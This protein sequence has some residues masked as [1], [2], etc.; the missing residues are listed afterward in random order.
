M[1]LYCFYMFINANEV[2]VKAWLRSHFSGDPEISCVYQPLA[3][4]CNCG[5]HLWPHRIAIRKC[6]KG[7][8]NAKLK[9][10]YQI[11]VIAVTLC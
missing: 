7:K 4:R 3:L 9:N 11:N 2:V 5:R 8:Q 6:M 1:Q 10:I